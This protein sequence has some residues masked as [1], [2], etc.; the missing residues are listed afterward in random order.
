MTTRLLTI[1]KFARATGL[2]YWLTRELVNRGDIPSLQVGPRRRVDARFIERW[3]QG[4]GQPAIPS[5]QRSPTSRRGRI[6]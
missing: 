3:T 5:T 4:I 1:P 2:T 6:Y